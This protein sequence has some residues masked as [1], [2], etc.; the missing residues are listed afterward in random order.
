MTAGSQQAPQ[1]TPLSNGGF[2]VTWQDFSAGVGGATGD[3]SGS[4]V[5]AQ[6]FLADGTRVGSELLVNTATAGDQFVPQFAALSAIFA[7]FFFRE[8]LARL[9]LVGVSTIVVGV[10]VLT[11]LRS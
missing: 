2:V 7:F 9:Q 5:K 11:A 1:V 3:S 10:A 8:R 4:A 6:V